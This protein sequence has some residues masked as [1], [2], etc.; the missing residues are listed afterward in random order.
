MTKQQTRKPEPSAQA[1][2]LAREVRA[3]RMTQEEA[4]SKLAWSMIPAPLRKH[5][6]AT[7]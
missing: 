3:G 2:E 1:Y 7:A 6:Q 5:L 4:S